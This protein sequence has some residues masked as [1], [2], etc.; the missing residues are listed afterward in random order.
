MDNRVDKTVLINLLINNEINK[1]MDNGEWRE[2][3]ASLMHNGHK[4][5][6]NYSFLELF[7][8]ALD[9]YEFETLENPE[10]NMEAFFAWCIN[11]SSA[12]WT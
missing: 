3:I 9:V 11:N 12:S 2:T 5:Y 6:Q 7:E 4:G 1:L 10:E 8:E